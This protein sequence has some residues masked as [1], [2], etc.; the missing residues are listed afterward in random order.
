MAR[1]TSEAERLMLFGLG[2]LA[3]GAAM[4]IALGCSWKTGVLKIRG[5]ARFDRRQEPRAFW[6]YFLAFAV[7]AGGFCLAG[8]VIVLGALNS[9]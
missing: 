1:A 5:G 7:V 4:T 6:F 2:A 3:V 9:N 8:A